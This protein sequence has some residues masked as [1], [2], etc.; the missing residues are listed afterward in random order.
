MKMDGKQNNILHSGLESSR[1]SK[2]EREQPS[3]PLPS[4][5]ILSQCCASVLIATV[6]GTRF[7]AAAS[8]YITDI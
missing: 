5:P 1:R 6:P 7:V 3:P 2:E 4:F 8:G